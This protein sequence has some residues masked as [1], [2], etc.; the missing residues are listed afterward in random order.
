MIYDSEYLNLKHIG[1]NSREVSSD[2]IPPTFL[3]SK[4]R[5]KSSRRIDK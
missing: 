2:I 3:K 5:G 1:G 4:Y